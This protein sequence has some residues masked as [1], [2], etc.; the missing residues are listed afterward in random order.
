[1]DLK[2]KLIK[3]ARFIFEELE[4]WNKTLPPGKKLKESLFFSYIS[5]FGDSAYKD[6]KPKA[7]IDSLA[8]FL[9]RNKEAYYHFAT[10]GMFGNIHQVL[11]YFL[12]HEKKE[13]YSLAETLLKKSP[14]GMAAEIRRLTEEER[15]EWIGKIGKNDCSFDGRCDGIY[16]IL[17]EEEK[18]KDLEEE[19]KRWSLIKKSEDLEIEESRLWVHEYKKS[20]ILESQFKHI[21]FGLDRMSIFNKT[22]LKDSIEVLEELFILNKKVYRTMP[23]TAYEIFS[24]HEPKSNFNSIDNLIVKYWT[25]YPEIHSSD[26]KTRYRA[27]GK[28]ANDIKSGKIH[29]PEVEMFGFSKSQKQELNENQIQTEKFEQPKLKM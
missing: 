3:K 8:E 11:R 23:Q 2:E 25:N 19:T 22:Y 14:S 26:K 21:S 13:P 9:A 7:S 29:E 16:S 6:I 15:R 17:S 5:N 4:Y 12:L 24:T 18:I 1:M 27:I 28:F 10:K 20:K